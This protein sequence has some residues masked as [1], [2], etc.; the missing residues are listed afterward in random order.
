[1]RPSVVAVLLTALA[2]PGTLPGQTNAQSG[3]AI[4]L[5]GFV[6]GSPGAAVRAALRCTPCPT[7]ANCDR[8]VRADGTTAWLSRDT[9]VGVML[10]LEVPERYRSPGREATDWW[11]RGL[12]TYAERLFGPADTI[13]SFSAGQ[14]S[15]IPTVPWGS[16]WDLLTNG[17]G[18]MANWFRHR[19]ARW[20]ARV[21]LGRVVFSGSRGFGVLSRAEVYLACAGRLLREE[22][23]DS[24]G[25]LVPNPL[26]GP[27]ASCPR[28][29]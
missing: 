3:P 27:T 19:D 11:E 4:G 22:T 5:S 29:P 2:L 15:S 9:I 20:D 10:V 14:G 12:R 21:V 7:E 1:M 13:S 26:L 17:Q 18:L 6:L 23:P 28:A 24:A 8:C 25:V 16:E